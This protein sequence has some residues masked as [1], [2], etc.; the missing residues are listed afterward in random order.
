LSP[1]DLPD[2]FFCRIKLFRDMKLRSHLLIL[3]V[4]ALLP[5]L[6]FASAVVLI[7]S[8]NV[9]ERAEN[10]LQRTA[11][12]LSLD[13]DRELLVSIRTLEALATSEHLD[14]GDLRKFYQQAQRVLKTN[15]RWENILLAEP[16]GQQ[17]INLRLPFG[18]PLPKSAELDTL[19]KV[20]ETRRPVVT[21]LF[22]GTIAT[23]YLVGVDVP[24]I[25]DGKVRYV[26][27][28]GGSPGFLSEIL[29]EEKPSPD[30]Y[31]AVIDRNK[32]VIARSRDVEQFVGKPAIPPFT[33][34]SDGGREGI[35]RSVF[36]EAR[37]GYSAVSQSELS[38]WTVAVA[39]PAS[40]FDVPVRRSIMTLI[41]GGIG[42]VLV[43]AFLA[44]ALGSRLANSI[45]ALAMS[46]TA[47]GHGDVQQV[48]PSPIDEVNDVA[49]ALK[50]AGAERKQAEEALRKSREKLRALATHLQSMREEEKTRIARELH[51]EIG[52][53]LTGIKLSLERSLREP[54]NV[55]AALE[56]A[57]KLCNE[58]IGRVRD[59]SLELR[60]S[61]LDDF[62]LLAALTWH[63][64]RYT[65]QVNV[66]VEFK[67]AGLEERRFAPEIETAVYR[68]VQE[69]LTNV[70]RHARVDKVEVDI[71]AD[72]NMLRIWIRDRGAGFVPSAL[73]PNETGGLSG[74][75]ERAMML[76]GW[77][78]IESA[79]GAGTVLMTILSL[80]AR[81]ASGTDPVNT[82]AG[83]G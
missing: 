38:G 31:A 4:A 12:D 66:A 79:P 59:L 5:V 76:G 65:S 78:K 16:S 44:V 14:S 68:I 82:R 13:I 32:T 37:D 47:L 26:L 60:P 56:P 46:A 63:F 73:S 30:W 64:S 6:I 74:I 80:S 9:H 17:L 75:R 39:A 45:S 2:G 61:V 52:Q 40:S 1:L 77:L 23:K 72:D 48:P 55:T 58:L 54:N 62:G 67:H 50:N 21:E 34:S 15:E 11:H 33:E 29:R 43:G 42:F 51:D 35:S 49:R 57:L 19:K 7:H 69:A 20:L 36:P 10:G 41:I 22:R 71:R 53:T 3:V 24:V 18:S 83:W 27:A 81:F 70:A 28:S 25:R 8:S